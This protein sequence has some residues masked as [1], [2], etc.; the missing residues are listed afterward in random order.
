MKTIEAILEIL[1]LS[2]LGLGFVVEGHPLGNLFFF[3]ICGCFAYAI[4]FIEDNKEKG[5]QNGKS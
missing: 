3:L 4:V 1:C 2:F 5:K